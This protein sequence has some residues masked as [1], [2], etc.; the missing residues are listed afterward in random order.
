MD[1]T[2]MAD[3][4]FSAALQP[5]TATVAYLTPVSRQVLKPTED[6]SQTFSYGLVRTS[7]RPDVYP[8]QPVDSS[9]SAPFRNAGTGRR[10]ERRLF[11]LP[12]FAD[13]LADVQVWL[14]LNKVQLARACR[15]ERQTIYDWFARAYEPVG[16]NADRV[17]QLYR[18]AA[19]VRERG[20]RPLRPN[21]AEKPLSEGVSLLATIL[22][23][24]IDL[25]R[26]RAATDALIDAVRNEPLRTGD[27]LRARLG[28]KPLSEEQKQQNLDHNLERLRNR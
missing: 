11:A 21:V 9:Q 20:S 28:W 22:A 6:W 10:D 4:Q 7:T 16:A 15:V 24:F 17:A 26:A 18:L 27:A 1:S 13:Q 2:G 3:D 19:H 12:S 23:P 25:D 8:L 5:R 14:G